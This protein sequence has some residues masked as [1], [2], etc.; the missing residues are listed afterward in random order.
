MREVFER[1]VH[2]EAPLS[3]MNDMIR[4][5]VK[6][7]AGDCWKRLQ[8]DRMI[9]NEKYA[10]DV[11]LQKTYIENHLTHRQI[12]NK[13]DLP[14]FRVTDAHD[15]IVDRHIFE[16]AQMIT[17]MRRVKDGNSTYPYGDMLRCPHCGKVLTHGSLYDFYYDG[18]H[19]QNGGW[20]CY[21][22]GGC[23]E[24]LLIQNVLDQAMIG[25]YAEKYIFLQLILPLY[26]RCLL[27]SGLWVLRSSLQFRQRCINP[28]H[29]LVAD[30][31]CSSFAGRYCVLCDFYRL[32]ECLLGDP[33]FK[34]QHF[35]WSAFEG[36]SIAVPLLLFPSSPF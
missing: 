13:G 22:E 30:H 5:G 35:I 32:A 10:G 28:I 24:Y 19:I 18:K 20:G 33:Q 11:V 6:P 27:R 2:G 34:Y 4:R 31:S 23:G 3:I 14:R 29:H 15:A 12:R 8:I 9:K 36:F 17:A 21:S 16:Q 26:L 25:A 7:P 1:Y